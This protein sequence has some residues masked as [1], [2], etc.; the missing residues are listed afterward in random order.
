MGDVEV[1]TPGCSS[2]GQGAGGYYTAW[3]YPPSDGWYYPEG[4]DP[5]CTWENGCGEGP[6]PPP[7]S[8]MKFSVKP[9]CDPK[10]GQGGM[11]LSLNGV[12][13]GFSPDAVKVTTSTPGV[14]LPGGP[15]AA[16][17]PSALI[18]VSGVAPGQPVTF[19]LCAFNAAEMKSGKPFTCCR[20][21]FTVTAPDKECKKEGQ[22]K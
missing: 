1:Y 10:T 4:Q 13:A 15:L 9:V 8:C 12:S 3:N 20:A 5:A 22:P 11:S 14:T 17:S 2:G 21:T 19:S 7:S 16:L 6:P 18:P